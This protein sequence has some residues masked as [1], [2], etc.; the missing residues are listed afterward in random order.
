M[1]AQ[2]TRLAPYLLTVLTI[3]G[4]FARRPDEFL[5]PYIR[6]E[7]GYD[8]RMS[9][10]MFRAGYAN[11]DRLSQQIDPAFTPDFWPRVAS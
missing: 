2:V 7:D 3:G 8:S 6:V 5:H 9:A 4:F 10:A 1:K 11:H